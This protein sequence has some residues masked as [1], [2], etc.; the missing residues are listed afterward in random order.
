MKII[1]LFP[2]PVGM[3]VYDQGLTSKEKEYLLD[4]EQTPN[5]GNSTS[6]NNTILRTKSL[7]A[8]KTWLEQSLL[9]YFDN[10]HRPHTDVSIQITQSWVNY[11]QTGQFHHKHRHPNS[12]VSGVFFIQSDPNLDKIYFYKPEPQTNLKIKPTSYNDWNSESWWLEAA[13]NTLY[14]FPSTLDHMV[15]EVKTEST[16]V[17]L[18]FNTFLKGK[19]GC[20]SELTFLEVL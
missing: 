4:L 14:L 8:L 17:S 18:S 6:K 16:R 1:N 15:Q 13:P 12:I 10:V 2:T 11:T 20:E 9:A 19:V 7:K 3:Y 5:M